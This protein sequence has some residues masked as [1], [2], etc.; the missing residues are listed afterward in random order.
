MTRAAMGTG[1]AVSTSTTT[2]T[3]TRS[4]LAIAVV[5][6]V[7]WVLILGAVL[8]IGWLLTHPLE[9][10]VDPWDDDAA[11][12]FAGERTQDLNAVADVGTIL[13]ETIVGM[14][15]AAVVAAGLSWWRR[16][17]LPA[18]FVGLLVAGIGGF[19]WVATQL[20]ARDRPPVRI[21][22]PGLV[23]DHSFPSGHV[24]TATAVY[25]GLAVLVWVLAP[26]ARR[27]VWLLFLLPPFVA[28]ARLYEGAHHVTDV[29]TSLA[30]TT[31]WLAV[32]VT[33]LLVRD[34]SVSTER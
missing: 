9:S 4:G 24:A 2:T 28:L 13:G 15:V 27:W 5:V 7:A 18:I 12:W 25:G 17:F 32:L 11:R 20:I 21:L 6:L 19:Y 1:S 23:P 14:G 22:D 30:Y 8:T 33:V 3:S 16:S 34:R 10:T 29:L 31:A 26:T